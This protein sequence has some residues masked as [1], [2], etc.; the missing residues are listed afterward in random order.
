MPTNNSPAA[1]LRGLLITAGIGSA[2]AAT[3]WRITVGRQMDT[4]DAQITLYDLPGTPGLPTLLLDYPTIQA[5][6]R[7]NR[8]DYL[9]TFAKIKDVRA[10]LNGLPPQDIDGDHYSGIILGTDINFLEYDNIGRPTFTV[11]FNAFLE[12]APD[13]SAFERRVSL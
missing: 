3:P 5:R 8:D 11:S 4:P 9:G 13:N 2:D 12:R 6:V 10:F 7:G 1:Q